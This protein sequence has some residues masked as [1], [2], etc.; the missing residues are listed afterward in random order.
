MQPEIEFTA[1]P[2]SADIAALGGLL[3]DTRPGDVPPWAPL[4][5]AFLLRRADGTIEGGLSGQTMWNWAHVDLLV[6]PAERRGR[7]LG[8]DLLGRAEAEARRRGCTDIHL[9]TFS[10]QAK[11]FYER[12]GYRQWGELPGYPGR[13]TRH[14]MTKRL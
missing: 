14:F 7:G 6:L 10:W 3:G 5:F 9:N 12:L 8:R 11:P 1:A 2:S 4:P 13:H